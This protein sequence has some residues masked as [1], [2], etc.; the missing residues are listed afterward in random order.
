MA[1]LRFGEC[2]PVNHTGPSARHGAQ[3]RVKHQ[4]GVCTAKTLCSRDLCESDTKA[5]AGQARGC[6]TTEGRQQMPQPLPNAPGNA[7]P[8]K[9]PH[10]GS[11]NRQD[12]SPLV[13]MGP[14]LQ[15]LIPGV[16][17]TPGGMCPRVA[18]FRPEK[19][20]MLGACVCSPGYPDPQPVQSSSEPL[21][22]S[23]HP[24]PDG[25]GWDTLHPPTSPYA[26][27]GPLQQPVPAPP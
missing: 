13:L 24:L 18:L 11:H 1:Q 15:C 17:D 2:C 19:G 25:K 12:K 10:L 27:A 4:A 23:W 21:L 6:R 5:H 26:G 16:E 7:V 14:R 20:Q 3:V 9:H 22:W 8:G